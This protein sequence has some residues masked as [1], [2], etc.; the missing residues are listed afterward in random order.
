MAAGERRRRRWFRYT[1]P[2]AGG[3][4]LFTCLAF[5]PS[6]LPRSA[7]VQGLV[8]GISAAIGYGVGVVAA[9]VWRAFADRDERP[10]RSNAWRIFAVVAVVALVAAFVLGQRWQSEIRNL[11]GVAGSNPAALLLV[12][13]VAAVVFVA[14]GRT[15]PR[16]ARGSTAGWPGCSGAGSDRGRPARS[17][18]SPS[19]AS[20]SRWSAVSCWTGSCPPPT[21][22]S[23]YATRITTEGRAAAHRRHPVRRTRIPGRLGHPGPR[24]PQVHRAGADRVGHL[25]VH[26]RAGARADPRVRGP[27]VGRLDRG[28]REPGG[29]RPGTRR[30]VR[31]QVSRRRH[32][33]RQRLGRPGARWT[34]SST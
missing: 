11:M 22:R 32:D 6:L 3:A 18:G 16:P 17:A 20:P 25:R 24:G 12:P 21:R 1:L 13:V 10:A 26:R 31:P 2:G 8:C 29:R 19:S 23:P 9:W 30:R 4:L 33:H 28:P 5:T 34:R 27:G 7:L 15:G 14:P